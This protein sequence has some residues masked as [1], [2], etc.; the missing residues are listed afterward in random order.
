ML[1]LAA[2]LLLGAGL[3]A[4][5]RWIEPVREAERE[6]ARGNTQAAVDAY[7]AA[8]AR[9]GRFAVTRYVFAARHADA[10]Y[11]QLALLY[12]AGEYSAVADKAASAPA[13]AAPRFWAGTALLTRALAEEDSETRLQLATS[14]EQELG[15]A[16]H[17]APGDWDTKVNYEMAARLVTGLR[18]DPKIKGDLLM[19]LLRPTPA[20]K[21]GQRRVG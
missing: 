7:A 20:E 13:G 12:R 17:A 18:R 21:P 4:Y 10:V 19:R 14:A 5:V 3:L 16:L 15:Q 1:V 6:L 11:N 8:E 9:F 2:A